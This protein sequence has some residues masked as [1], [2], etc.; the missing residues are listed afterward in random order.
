MRYFFH[1]FKNQNATTTDAVKQT[2]AAVIEIWLKSEIPIKS[3][4]LHSKQLLKI[5][6]SWKKSMIDA[7]RR[8]IN[9]GKQLQKSNDLWKSLSCQ[10]L[11]LGFW[12]TIFFSEVAMIWFG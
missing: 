11:E 6:E 1:I 2:I 12:I 7:S 9:Y 3:N 10:L 4:W 5:F 8:N